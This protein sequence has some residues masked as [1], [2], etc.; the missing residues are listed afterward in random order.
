MVS[1]F[2]LGHQ[3]DDGDELEKNKHGSQ[4]WQASQMGTNDGICE[5]TNMN[6]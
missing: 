3:Q 1:T 6:M 2:E 5:K 4:T